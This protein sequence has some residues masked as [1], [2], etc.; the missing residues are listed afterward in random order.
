M[1]SEQQLNFAFACLF[2]KNLGVKEENLNSLIKFFKLVRHW[3]VYVHFY[4]FPLIE[5]GPEIRLTSSG[6]S[7]V[8]VNVYEGQVSQSYMYSVYQFYCYYWPTV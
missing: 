7:N 2:A 1:Q 3:L 8:D 6:F 5:A 4:L